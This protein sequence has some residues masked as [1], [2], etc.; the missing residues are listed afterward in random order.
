M[1]DILHSQAAMPARAFPKVSNPPMTA[2]A[3]AADYVGFRGK[4]RFA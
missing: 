2:G 1:R 4:D 3:D